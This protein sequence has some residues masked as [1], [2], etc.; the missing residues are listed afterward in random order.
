LYVKVVEIILIQRL[1]HEKYLWFLSRPD[2]LLLNLHLIGYIN[3]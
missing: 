1:K 2:A 3:A